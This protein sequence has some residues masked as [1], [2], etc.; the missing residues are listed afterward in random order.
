MYQTGNIYNQQQG[1][2]LYHT[3]ANQIGSLNALGMGAMSPS[4]FFYMG[5]VIGL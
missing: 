2:H 5:N 3:Y 4:T 1:Q